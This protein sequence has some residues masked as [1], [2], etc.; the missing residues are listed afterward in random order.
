MCRSTI[1]LVELCMHLGGKIILEVFD[2]NLACSKGCTNCTSLG[3]P[4]V[5]YYFLVIC[6]VVV[7]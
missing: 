4:V 6:M 2:E 1:A 5:A 3:T 7:S